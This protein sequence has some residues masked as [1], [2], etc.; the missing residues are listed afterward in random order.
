MNFVES[1]CTYANVPSMG[2]EHIACIS[3]SLHRYGI[4]D[5]C[6]IFNQD[7]SDIALRSMTDRSLHG[8]IDVKQRELYILSVHTK[9]NPDLM[10]IEGVVNAHS[11]TFKPVIVMP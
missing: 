2:A 9:E 6:H 3:T 5:K 7:E 4:T 10:T 1:A 11:D 8:A